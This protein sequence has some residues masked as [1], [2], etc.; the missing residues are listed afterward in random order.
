MLMC[1]MYEP[2]YYFEIGMTQFWDKSYFVFFL[3][4]AVLILVLY[5]I[6]W[7]FSKKKIGWHITA[8][9]FFVA[10]TLAL[11]WLYGISQDMIMDVIFHIL[12]IV[13][14]AAGV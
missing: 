4:I 10:D 12:V 8:L 9:V 13:D 2:E 5:F 1:G 3:S 6:C 11:L 7:F 14:L